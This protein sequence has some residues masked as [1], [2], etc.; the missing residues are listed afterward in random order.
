MNLNDGLPLISVVIAVYNGRSTLQQCI[1]SVN[2][3]TYQKVELIVMDGGSTDGTV[4]LL[5][6]NAQKLTYWATEPDTG[7][8]NA[9]NKALKKAKG[10]WICFLGA[11]DYFWDVQVLALMAE[12]LAL[13]SPDI[14]VAYGQIMLLAK[15]DEP[16]YPL[17]QPWGIVKARF[18]REMCLPHPAVMHRSGLFRRLGAFDESFRIAG[19]Y[20]LL[21]RELKDHAA[22]FI[23]DLIVTAMRQGGV[24]SS[25]NSTLTSLHEVRRAQKKAGLGW[26]G[27]NWFL[28]LLRAYVRLILWGLAGEALAR[29]LLDLGRRVLGLP[30]YWT[31][32]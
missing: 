25:P 13:V 9:W 12:K 22:I 4:D 5:I 3:Q 10:D 28:A 6:A 14:N 21:L 29:K 20:E 16:M 27:P 30:A 7:I 32:T 24:S 18:R 1:D 31:R 26:P 15:G 23:P 17:G 8:Y 2:Q 11:D 19:D